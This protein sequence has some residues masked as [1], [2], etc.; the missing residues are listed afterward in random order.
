MA[1]DA[2]GIIALQPSRVAADHEALYES[3]TFRGFSEDMLKA[4]KMR[5]IQA[6]VRIGSRPRI[7]L[8]PREFTLSLVDLLVNILGIYCS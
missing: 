3:T 7:M 8:R 5:D 4:T 2:D 6:P 1:P